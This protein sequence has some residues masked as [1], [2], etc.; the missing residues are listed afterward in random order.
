MFWF[1]KYHIDGIRVDAVAFMLYLD[2]GRDSGTI[3]NEYGK[4][5]TCM[6]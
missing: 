4:N 1:D 6:P 2:Y 5:E 3:L